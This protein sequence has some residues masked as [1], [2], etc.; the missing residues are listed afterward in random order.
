[1]AKL[2][3]PTR[4]QILNRIAELFQYATQWHGTDVSCE[5]YLHQ[6]EALIELLEV[7]DYGSIGGFDYKN[8]VIAHTRHELYNRFLAL[9]NKYGDA[10]R[11]KKQCHFDLISMGEYYSQLVSL[12]E[13]FNK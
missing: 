4:I 6:A 5:K 2:E 8:P 9:V 10:K 13:T 7:T 11:I 12:R 1:M 3:E